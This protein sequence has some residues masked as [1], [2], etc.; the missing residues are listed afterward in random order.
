MNSDVDSPELDT[1]IKELQNQVRPYEN[2]LPN[3]KS[4]NVGFKLPHLS[5]NMYYAGIPIVILILL[6]YFRPSFVKYEQINEDGTTT[7]HLGFKKVLVWTLVL[8]KVCIA[9]LFG[10]S[11]K[12]KKMKLIF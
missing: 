10:Y 1:V 11:Y 6:V 2:D 7:Y 12:K 9:G 8:S 5:P 3:T 4:K